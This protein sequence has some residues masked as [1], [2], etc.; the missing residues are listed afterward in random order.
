MSSIAL[1]DLSNNNETPDFRQVAGAGVAGCW[2]KV[3][4]GDAFTDPTYAT[5]AVAARQ[6]GLRVGGYHFA[7]PYRPADAQARWFAEHL[8]PIGPHDLRPVLDLELDGGLSPAQLVAWARAFNRALVELVHVGPILYTYTAF[9]RE[10]HAT[11]PIGYGLWLADYG[12]DDGREHTASPPAPWRHLVAHQYTSR[13]TV[14]GVVGSVDRTSANSL[15]PLLAHPT[16]QE[17]AR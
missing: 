3:T 8:G 17:P 1:I 16:P 12:P 7:Q 5:R 14:P 10:L 15:R 6:A 2:M 11:T 4:E 9:A 13:G